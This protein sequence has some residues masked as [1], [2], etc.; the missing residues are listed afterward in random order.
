MKV[1]ERCVI[2]DGHSLMY[3]AFHALPLMDADGV[4]TN[5]VHGFLSMLLRV[6]REQRPQYCAVA[7]DD[8]TPTFRHEGYEAYKAGRS[9]MP[10]ELRPQFPLIQELLS[11]MGIGVVIL[12]RWEADDVLGTISRQANERGIEALLLTGDRDALQLVSD[13]VTLLYL[14]RGVSEMARYTPA[15]VEAMASGSSTKAVISAS[16]VNWPSAQ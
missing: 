3:R 2:V 9:P 4:Y 12:P 1:Q 10:E 8:H 14:Q 7:F 6:F 11:A 16:R 5:A 13:Q 15:A